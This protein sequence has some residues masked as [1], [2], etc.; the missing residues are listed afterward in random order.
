MSWPL[1]SSEL[2]GFDAEALR[3]LLDERLAEGRVS[4]LDRELCELCGHWTV[5]L[6]WSP[7]IACKAGVGAATVARSLDRLHRLMSGLK[8]VYAQHPLPGNGSRD[9]IL[10]RVLEDSWSLVAQ[11][12]ATPERF[13]DALCWYFEAMGLPLSLELED[14]LELLILEG[15]LDSEPAALVRDVAEYALLGLDQ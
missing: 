12:D 1:M 13:V 15:L 14:D 6:D 5:A 4:G 2:D 8:A 7:Q 10:R 11:L 9:A 3:E